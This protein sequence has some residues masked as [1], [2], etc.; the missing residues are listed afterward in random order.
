MLLPLL[1]LIQNVRLTNM[2]VSHNKTRHGNTEVHT[3]THLGKAVS[4]ITC[5]RENGV[6]TSLMASN[7]SCPAGLFAILIRNVVAPD[8]SSLADTDFYDCELLF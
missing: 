4:V 7:I 8:A 3:Y 2:D 6:V 1:L 5:I